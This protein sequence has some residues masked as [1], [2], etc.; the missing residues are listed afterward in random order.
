MSIE[1]SNLLLE[2]AAR[3]ESKPVPE[4]AFET[5]DKASAAFPDLLSSFGRIDAIAQELFRWIDESHSGRGHL[6]YSGWHL[7]DHWGEPELV[8]R[9]I[10]RDYEGCLE[11]QSEN[12]PLSI[13]FDPKAMEAERARRIEAILAQASAW[14]SKASAEKERRRKQFEDL[15]AEFT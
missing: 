3:L 11:D 2:R 4:A 5:E 10:E 14:E 1:I 6:R 13:L 7:S 15:R 12:F 9:W 8:L